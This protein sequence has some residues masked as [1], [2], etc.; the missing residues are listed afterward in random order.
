MGL[1]RGAVPHTHHI[2]VFSSSFF[3]FYFF[4]DEPQIIAV[5]TDQGHPNLQNDP[6]Q[7]RPT[8]TTLEHVIYMAQDQ[9]RPNIIWGLRRKFM[10]GL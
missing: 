2:L 3:I 4:K 8:I 5:F 7:H 1:K 9:G 6:A 10:R